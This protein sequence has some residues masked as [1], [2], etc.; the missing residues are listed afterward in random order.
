MDFEKIIGNDSLKSLIGS[1][2]RN[3]TLSH[4]Y[5][6][7]GPRYSGKKTL[8][9]EICKALCCE[10]KKD[11][12]PCGICRSCKRIEEGYNTDIYTL[13]SGDKASIQVQDVRELTSTLGYYPDDG[14]VKIY[15]I[16]EADK[17]TTPAQNALL[18]SLEEPPEYVVFLLL[19]ENSLN[20]LETV[21]SRAQIFRTQTFSA[22]FTVKWLRENAAAKKASDEAVHI[23]ATVSRGALGAALLALTDKSSAAASIS[24]DA[25]KLVELLCKNQKSDTIAFAS[26]IKYSRREFED[27]FDYALFA[28]RDLLTVK[29]NGYDTSYYPDAD[30]AAETARHVKL[31]KLYNIYSALVSAKD[32]ITKNN[33]HIYA[34]MMTLAASAM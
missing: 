34:V 4:A 9:K 31:S 7:E 24:K 21:R 12:L 16:E 3:K 29:C 8:A 20:L 22:D 15:I 10:N 28:V 23:A 6:I 2:I 17:L 27:F 1:H 26:G 14:D 13:N 18:L 5:I 33:A 25:G 11:T 19:S 32:D 30:T